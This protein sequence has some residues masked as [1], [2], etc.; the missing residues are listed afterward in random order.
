VLRSWSWESWK[1]HSQVTKWILRYLG[2]VV[3][4]SLVVL[5]VAPWTIFDSNYP[6]ELQEDTISLW[7]SVHWRSVTEVLYERLWVRTNIM[8]VVSCMLWILWLLVASM[9]R[10]EIWCIMNIPSWLVLGSLCSGFLFKSLIRRK[11]KA[12][13]IILFHPQLLPQF[14]ALSMKIP[15]CLLCWNVLGTD[16]WRLLFPI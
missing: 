7:Y 11:D 15:K 8:R 4:V 16:V 1:T 3:H 10:L 5:L 9:V 12:G 13:E 2:V 6:G 14:A